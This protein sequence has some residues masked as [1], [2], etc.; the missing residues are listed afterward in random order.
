MWGDMIIKSD[1]DRQTFIAKALAVDL[2]KQPWEFIAHPYKRDRNAEQNA[3]IN[4]SYSII[5]KH[6]GWTFRHTRGYYKLEYGVPIILERGEPEFIAL[7]NAINDKMTYEQKIDLFGGDSIA[8][9][10]IMNIKEA[11]EYITR[12]EHDCFEKGIPCRERSD[13]DTIALL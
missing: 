5:S 12:M 4:K 7:I 10:S 2:E 3:L 1:K 13:Y 6:Q 8:I 11:S 9:T